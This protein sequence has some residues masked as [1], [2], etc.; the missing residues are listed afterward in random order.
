[1]SKRTG[2]RGWLPG[3]TL[4]SSHLLVGWQKDG[5]KGPHLQWEFGAYV[6]FDL[7]WS[8]RHDYRWTYNYPAWRHDSKVCMGKEPLPRFAFKR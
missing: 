7:A 1:M 6:N 4:D 5:W 3:L 2:W 8:D